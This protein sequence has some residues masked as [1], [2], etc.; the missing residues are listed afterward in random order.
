MALYRICWRIWFLGTKDKRLKTEEE[1]RETMVRENVVLEICLEG[2]LVFTD[3][4]IFVPRKPSS[5]ISS[6]SLLASAKNGLAVKILSKG[7][8]VPNDPVVDTPNTRQKGWERM[9]LQILF[10]GPWNLLEPNASFA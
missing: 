4:V 9:V 2:W 6:E 8:Q 3:A 1:D 7:K 5:S 10:L